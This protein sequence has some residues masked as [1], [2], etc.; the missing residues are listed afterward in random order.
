MNV[1]TSSIDKDLTLE[2]F[3]SEI[4]ENIEILR[5]TNA[6]NFVDKQLGNYIQ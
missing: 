5:K 6:K 4:I 1:F 3:A 2:K